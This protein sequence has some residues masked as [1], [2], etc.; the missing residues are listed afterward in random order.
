MRRAAVLGIVLAVIA[1]AIIAGIV[2]YQ[3]SVALEKSRQQ[4][5][6][7]QKPLT[8]QIATQ[9]SSQKTNPVVDIP[10]KAS[11]EGAVLQPFSPAIINIHA[12]D[13]VTWVNHD[14]SQH[15]V[16]TAL[17][18]SGVIAAQ[19]SSSAQAPSFKHTFNQKGIFVYSCKIHPFM[20]GVVYVD[21]EETQ[22]EIVDTTNSSIFIVKVEMPQNA[23]YQNKYGPYFIPANAIIPSSSRLTWE[24][25]DF[26]A[27]T[28]TSTDGR[29]FDTGNVLPGS[30]I[31]IVVPRQ[32][33]I[34]PY[35]CKIHP[36][37]VGI[38]TVSS[39]SSNQ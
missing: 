8:D 33:G 10:P 20:G 25:H 14:S 9:I 24:N 37:M 17:F 6:A 36:W 27:H 30:S 7:T 26:I 39:P 29:T 12:G 22:R 38:V 23:A 28:A 16:T 13:T 15:T 35:Y 11:Q 5:Q 1:A 3:N 19:N 31:S 2:P 4:Q 32:Q 21:T 18:D 34:F